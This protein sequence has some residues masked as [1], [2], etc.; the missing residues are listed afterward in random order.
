MKREML[1]KYRGNKSQAELAKR[2][3]VSQQVWSRWE[4]GVCKPPV[5]TMKKLENDIGAPMEDIF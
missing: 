4:N 1:V 5:W 3:G 2:Y